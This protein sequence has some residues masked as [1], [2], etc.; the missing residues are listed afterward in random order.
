MIIIIFFT[1]FT[2]L[3]QS[4]GITTFDKYCYNLSFGLTTKARTC[5][6]AG[7][8]GSSGVPYHALKN[9]GECEK[10]NTHTL[11]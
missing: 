6:G 4:Y 8:E 9:V 10:M 11:K 5:K 2:N 3:F 1:W 7:Q